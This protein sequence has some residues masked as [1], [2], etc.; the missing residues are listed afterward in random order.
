V[1]L[2][3]HD[4]YSW[5]VMGKEFIPVQEITESSQYIDATIKTWFADMTNAERNQL[6]DVMFTLLGSGGVDTV[7]E[8]LQPKNIR[9][10]I[11][12]L[13]SDVGI[14]R[15]LSTEFQSLIEAA[16]KTK[17]RFEEEKEL[18]E[19]GNEENRVELQF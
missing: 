8:L 19:A 2:L 14:R 9:T 11:K 1:G 18:L 6:V 13:S 15:V 3:Q 5:E 10:Y 7:Q 4:P 12:T 16:R 17:L